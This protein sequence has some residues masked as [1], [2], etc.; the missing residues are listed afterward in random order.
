[1]PPLRILKTTRYHLLLGKNT[2]VFSVTPKVCH[3]DFLPLVK[4]FKPKQ[5]QNNGIKSGGEGCDWLGP[6]WIRKIA[7]ERTRSSGGGGIAG[8]LR[9]VQLSGNVG[10]SVQLSGNVGKSSQ[11]SAG[12]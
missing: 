10:N 12:G 5:D 7:R 11:V 4:A 2:E 8:L 3:T 6:T 9:V 1:M